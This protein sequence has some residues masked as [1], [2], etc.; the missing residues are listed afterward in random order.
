MAGCGVTLGAC[1]DTIGV[2]VREFRLHRVVQALIDVLYWIAATIFVFR[3]LMMANYG[4]VRFFIFIGLAMGVILYALMLGR[5]FRRLV[6][7]LIRIIV[8]VVKFTIRTIRILVIRPLLF[9]YNVL[10]KI[11]ITIGGII[12]SLSI[13]FSK[14]VIQ[15]SRIVWKWI[16]SKSTKDSNGSEE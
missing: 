16:R 6:E 2:A 1:F 7:I 12:A 15:W 10:Y 8:R 5:P 3:V 14:I 13:Y 9:L 11:I 4:E